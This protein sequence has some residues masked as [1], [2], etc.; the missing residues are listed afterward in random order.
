MTFLG[1]LGDVIKTAG[2][3]VASAD[4]EQTL[5]AFAGVDAAFAVPVAHPTRGE[6]VAAFVIS[7]GDLDAIALL[8]HCRNELAPYKVPRHIFRLADTD[9][10]TL[11][12]GKVDRRRLRASFGVS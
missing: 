9:L 11:G 6:N 3:N 5:A 2:V 7:R 12:S 4:V 10:P 1:R 8:Q